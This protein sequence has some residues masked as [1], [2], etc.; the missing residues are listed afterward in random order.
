[1]NYSTSFYPATILYLAVIISIFA[2]IFLMRNPDFGKLLVA[3]AL[4]NLTKIIVMAGIFYGFITIFRKTTT[5]PEN[6]TVY[7]FLTA[8]LILLFQAVN[9][10]PPSANVKPVAT[11][12]RNYLTII[13]ISSGFLYWHISRIDPTLPKFSAWIIGLDVVLA[14]VIVTIPMLQWFYYTMRNTFSISD[15]LLFR[16]LELFPRLQDSKFIISGIFRNIIYPSFCASISLGLVWLLFIKTTNLQTALFG[17]YNQFLGWET[18]TSYRFSILFEQ[19]KMLFGNQTLATIFGF[20]AFTI[21]L[22][23]S[24]SSLLSSIK[25]IENAFKKARE[26]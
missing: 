20:S 19:L 16:L 12:T 6:F 7:I 5:I 25:I 21:S 4:E 15:F 14:H 9:K 26:D 10:I 8:I 11:T 1:M 3:L 22:T 13:I 18:S 23:L 2:V 17:N 24:F